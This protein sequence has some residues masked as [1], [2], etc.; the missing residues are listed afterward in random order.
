MVHRT[1][2][3]AASQ[4]KR[5][6]WPLFF[7]LVL[8]IISLLLHLEKA[9]RQKEL[10]AVKQWASAIVR[11]RPVERVKA[12]RSRFYQIQYYLDYPS[13]TSYAVADFVSRLCTAVPP[14]QV[15]DLQID[16][17]MQNFSF[18]LTLSIDA[19]RPGTAQ[20]AAAAYLEA[21]RKFPEIIQI[22]LAD[23]D[24]IEGSGGGNRA[25]FFTITGQA[26]MQ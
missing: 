15:R 23:I 11:D 22:A 10:M 18:R 20:R 8:T 25:Y 5:R 21:M 14:R 17:G 13:A 16:P 12:Q 3:S 24:P 2:Y 26:D 7:F 4:P 6:V 1:E 19:G 9:H